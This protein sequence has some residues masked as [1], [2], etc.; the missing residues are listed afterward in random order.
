MTKWKIGNSYIGK[1][2]PVY[3]IAEAGINHNGNLKKAIKMIDEAKLAGANAIKFQTFLAEDLTSKK[4][5]YFKLFKNLEFSDNDF[6]KLSDYSKKKKIEFLSTP[7]SFKAVDLLD[8]LNVAAFKIASGD[9][10]NI[11]LIEYASSKKKPMILSTGMSKIS[12]IKEAVKAI[13]SQK[14]NYKKH[15]FINNQWFD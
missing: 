14:N 8:E 2:E 6:K 5:K 13:N 12:E 7:F 9:I 3:I 10:T 11:P 1:N 4:S 15:E